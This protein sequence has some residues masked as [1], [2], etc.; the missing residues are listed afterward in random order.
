MGMD[1]NVVFFI[2]KS[3]RL[4]MWYCIFCGALEI[5]LDIQESF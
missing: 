1:N 2:I 3:K 5:G 4:H